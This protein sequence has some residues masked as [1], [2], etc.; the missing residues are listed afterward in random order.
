MRTYL[1]AAYNNGKYS[2]AD[3]SADVKT[4]T[5]SLA[6]SLNTIIFRQNNSEEN[7]AYK[8][9]TYHEQRCGV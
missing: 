5:S 3:G 2:M 9:P 8:T 1:C 6:H 4:T 7:L